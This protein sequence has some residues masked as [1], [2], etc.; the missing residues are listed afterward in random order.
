MMCCDVRRIQLLYLH[1]TGRSDRKHENFRLEQT[2]TVPTFEC[3]GNC[4]RLLVRDITYTCDVEIDSRNKTDAHF[5]TDLQ[6]T[7]L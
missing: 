5:Y 1:L 7:V 6:F 2:T 4:Y 3:E